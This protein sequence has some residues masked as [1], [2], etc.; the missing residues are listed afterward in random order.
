[1]AKNFG[2]VKKGTTLLLTMLDLENHWQ[3]VRVGQ[4]IAT[5]TNVEIH[6]NDIRITYK[7]QYGKRKF[8][9][10]ITVSRDETENHVTIPIKRWNNWYFSHIQWL[11]KSGYLR[12]GT[13]PEESRRE[14]NADWNTYLYNYVVE[15]I[16]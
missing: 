9:H 4:A 15:I 5:V 6:G 10:T 13:I 1:M 14:Y 2:T 16:Y 7:C 12:E 8:T 11:I 3:R